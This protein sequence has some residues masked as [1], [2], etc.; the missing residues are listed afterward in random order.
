MYPTSPKPATPVTLTCKEG[1]ISTA[2]PAVIKV[3]PNY[4]VQCHGCHCRPTADLRYE[5]PSHIVIDPLTREPYCTTYC[6]H[7]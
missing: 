2:D 1:T 6:H 7:S 4:F 3:G 5:L